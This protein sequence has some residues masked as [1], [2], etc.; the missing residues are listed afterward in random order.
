MLYVDNSRQ[1]YGSM[2]MSHMLADSTEELA[3]ACDALG[4]K[5][6]YIQY[7]GEPKEHVDVNMKKRRLA[8]QELGAKEVSGYDVVMMIR[9]RRSTRA[10]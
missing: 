3:S 6:E 7:P 9:Q 2:K 8:I 5:R 10:T 1:P 4:L